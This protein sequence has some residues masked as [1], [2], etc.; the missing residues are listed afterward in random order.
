M[1]EREREKMK[2]GE[3]KRERLRKIKDVHYPDCV[4]GVSVATLSPVKTLQVK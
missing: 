1:K 4:A 3:Q 2:G